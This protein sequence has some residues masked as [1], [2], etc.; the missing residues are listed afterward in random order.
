ML[1]LKLK[2]KKL[3]LVVKF[4]VLVVLRSV[5]LHV[6]HVARSV[7]LSAKNVRAHVL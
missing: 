7:L 6:S 3:V 1:K 4:L 5:K 2:Q